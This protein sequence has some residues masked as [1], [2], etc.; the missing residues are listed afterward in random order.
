MKRTAAE[1]KRRWRGISRQSSIGGQGLRCGNPRKSL[2]PP[3]D[4]HNRNGPQACPSRGHFGNERPCRATIVPSSGET[5][6][7]RASNLGRSKTK[8]VPRPPATEAAAVDS[9]NGS[10]SRSVYEASKSLGVCGGCPG[11][12]PAALRGGCSGTR[13]THLPRLAADVKTGN[14]GGS[15]AQLRAAVGPRVTGSGR[16]NVGH[17][18]SAPSRPG[19]YSGRRFS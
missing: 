5:Q 16:P 8:N 7:A 13:R 4:R 17:S 6:P 19:P 11:G 12:G 14:P 3:N 10:R 18:L 15:G 9:K 1:R 2:S